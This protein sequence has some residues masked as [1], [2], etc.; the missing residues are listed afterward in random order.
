MSR[1]HEFQLHMK[2]AAEQIEGPRGPCPSES[3]LI[4]YYRGQVDDG[5]RERLASHLSLCAACRETLL[6]AGHFFDAAPEKN[7]GAI[8]LDSEWR[9]FAEA[10]AAGVW[11]ESR[12]TTI[13]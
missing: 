6:D 3:T 4:A 8:D 7:T 1:R 2:A 5:D 12:V 13:R 9:K 10:K 11:S